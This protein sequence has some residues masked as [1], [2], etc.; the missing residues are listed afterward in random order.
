[1]ETIVGD[2]LVNFVTNKKY[3][4]ISSQILT[5]FFHFLKIENIKQKN[6]NLENKMNLF[7]YKFSV[8]F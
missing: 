2:L 3:L 7:G 4:L 1:M 6:I 8:I 5:I